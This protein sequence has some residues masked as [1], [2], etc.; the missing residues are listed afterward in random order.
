MRKEA[1]NYP[2]CG[3]GYAQAFL[4]GEVVD[5]SLNEVIKGKIPESYA[6]K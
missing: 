3:D 5:E 1:E 2:T 6:L 4:G